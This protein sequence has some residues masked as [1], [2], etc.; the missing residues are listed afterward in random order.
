MPWYQHHRIGGCQTGFK[1][2]AGVLPLLFQGRHCLDASTKIR[3]R[4]EQIRIMNQEGDSSSPPG[5]R[6]TAKEQ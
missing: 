3:S 2:A 5:V 4:I 6:E 1:Y